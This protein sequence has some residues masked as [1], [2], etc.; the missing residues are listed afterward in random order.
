MSKGGARKGAGRPALR[1]RC[2]NL[3]LYL[4]VSSLELVQELREDGVNMSKLF[5]ETVRRLYWKRKRQSLQN[6]KK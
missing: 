2:R 4:P 6:E 3:T 5:D 1:G